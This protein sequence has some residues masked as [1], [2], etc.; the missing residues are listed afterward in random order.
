MV[1]KY[2]LYFEQNDVPVRIK[3]QLVDGT[4]GTLVI[5]DDSGPVELNGDV[6]KIDGLELKFLKVTYHIQKY[7]KCVN[8]NLLFHKYGCI[9][10]ENL[11]IPVDTYVDVI[12]LENGYAFLSGKV[13]STTFSSVKLELE[14]RQLRHKE[15][16]YQITLE[17]GKQLLTEVFRV[18]DLEDLSNVHILTNQAAFR[19]TRNN[20]NLNSDY[21]LE[22]PKR[23]HIITCTVIRSGNAIIAKINVGGCGAICFTEPVYIECQHIGDVVL[24]SDR[25][26]IFIDDKR[27][28]Y[29]IIKE[30]I[31]NDKIIIRSDHFHGQIDFVLTQ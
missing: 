21:F 25:N 23:D 2:T 16:Y 20:V 30:L 9:S 24:L 27:R 28:E 3:G 6:I 29:L 31:G 11:H 18:T 17:N 26:D 22:F 5:S 1:R 15:R 13:V 10:G 19:V 7:V 12:T 4:T 8:G 14:I